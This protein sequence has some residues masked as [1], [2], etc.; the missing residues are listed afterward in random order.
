MPNLTLKQ[1]VDYWFWNKLRCC[2]SIEKSN[3]LVLGERERN[4]LERR[5][6]TT[7]EHTN[8]NPCRSSDTLKPYFRENRSA[9][10][11][12]IQK[13]TFFTTNETGNNV[14]TK[15]C[16]KD[17]YVFFLHRTTDETKTKTK[18]NKTQKKL[19][20]QATNTNF[21]L[22]PT[23][24]PRYLKDGSLKSCLRNKQEK[25]RN[26]KRRVRKTTL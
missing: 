2:A 10:E 26:T 25:M 15:P 6:P 11:N 23:H 14:L 7:R 4:E 17:D 9:N 20:T 8:Q 12:K 3:D 18:Q 5:I 21:P 22:R 24:Q 16:F 13:K 19:Q 1:K